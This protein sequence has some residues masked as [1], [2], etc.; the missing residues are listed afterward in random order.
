MLTYVHFS[1]V[2]LIEINI[3]LSMN[4]VVQAE[5]TQRL[6]YNYRYIYERT[7]QDFII[8]Y[9]KLGTINKHVTNYIRAHKT[10]LILRAY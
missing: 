5:R 8:G 4:F 3:L 10:K 1:I 9:C 7:I 6:N 2:R